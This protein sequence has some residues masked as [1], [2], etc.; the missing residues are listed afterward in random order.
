MDF[1][2]NGRR[3]QPDRERRHR[4][5]H[6]QGRQD[7]SQ[8]RVSQGAPESARGEVKY[9]PRYDPLVAANPGTGRDYAPT[10]WVASAGTPPEDDGP[11]THDIDVDVAII[12]SGST[13][14]STA[15]YLAQ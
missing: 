3:W 15:L 4:R 9:A 11:I 7:S 12:G 2:R 6:L 10:Y 13:G 5:V 8:E 1:H 14:I